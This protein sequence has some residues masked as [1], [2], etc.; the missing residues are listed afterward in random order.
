MLEVRVEED[1]R[2]ICIALQG[3][4]AGADV[5]EVHRAWRELAPRRGERQVRIDLRE[6]TCWSKAAVVALGKI[7]TQTNAGL[8]TGTA[9]SESLAL[10]VM[11]GQEDGV[12]IQAHEWIASERG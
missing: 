6:V 10:E 3:C 5:S 1:D 11:Y 4:V 8:R 7:Y 12:L 2:E 9:Q